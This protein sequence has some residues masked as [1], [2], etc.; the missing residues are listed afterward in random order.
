MFGNQGLFARQVVFRVRAGKTVLAAPPRKNPG[1]VPTPGQQVV[2]D[3]FS[4]A[5]IYAKA[6]LTDPAQKAAYQ[7]AAAPGVSAYN[8]AL[9]DAFKAPQVLG[10]DTSSYVGAASDTL[11][12][13]AVDDFKVARVKVSVHDP[14]GELVEEG[15]AVLQANGTDWL[16]SVS[17][18]NETATGSKVKAIA[19]DLPGN[20][21]FLEVTV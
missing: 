20:Q 18:E 5:V 6:A 15:D 12:I 9:A 8:R 11:V 3:K 13:K 7:A 17:G 16:Y 4:L 14:S 1:R 2:L 21:S 19:Y 10:I